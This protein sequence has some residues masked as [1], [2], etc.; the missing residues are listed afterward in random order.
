MFSNLRKVIFFVS[1][2]AV[3]YIAYAYMLKPSNRSFSQQK[4]Q[5]QSKRQKLAELQ[6]ATLAARDLGQQLK[7]LEDAISFFESR[8]PPQSQ[9]HKVLQQVTVIAQR[10]G[11]NTRSIQTLKTEGCSGYVE[12]PLKMELHGDFNCY[13]SF[14]LELERLPRITKIRELELKKDS[15]NEGQ[16]TAKFVVSIF[17]QDATG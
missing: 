16:A 14:L 4:L 17:F 8:L 9:I 2:A 11:L 7:Q 12:Q 6:Q 15:A 5:L 1:L 3:A 13:Y 10:Q